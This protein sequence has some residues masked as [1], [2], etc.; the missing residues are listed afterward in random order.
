MSLSAE[1]GIYTGPWINWSRGLVLGSTITLSQRDGSL[2]TAFLGIFVTVAGTAF[3]RILSFLIHQHRAKQAL[4]DAI[5]QQQQAILRNSGSPDAAAWQMTQLAWHWRKIASKPILRSLPFM[6]LAVCNIVLFAVA[7]VFSSEVT[8]AVGNET[9]IRSPNCGY[10]LPDKNAPDLPLSQALTGSYAMDA[11]D[12]LAASAYSRACYGR[13]QTG[14]QC[15]QYPMSHI[16]WANRTLSCPFGDDICK[17]VGGFE[18]DTEFIDSHKTLGLNA[19][20]SDRVQYRKVTTCSVL[21]TKE[22]SYW[23]SSPAMDP[24]Q[25]WNLAI[26]LYISVQYE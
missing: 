11:N 20:A 7:G 9:L 5:H 14:S 16:P 2:L 1:S 4:T 18:M 13:T 23:G 19:K 8:K 10:L 17:D 6:I 22:Y 25:L 3:W 21:R 24:L 12:T 26:E 15:Y